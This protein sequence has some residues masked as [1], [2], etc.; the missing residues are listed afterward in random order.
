[1]GIFFVDTMSRLGKN[2][3]SIPLIALTY[4]KAKDVEAHKRQSVMNRVV[5]FEMS[6]VV[7]KILAIVL[8]YILTSM[9]ADEALAFKISFVLAGSMSLLYMLL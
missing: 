1:M 3:V 5:F 6:L 8:V 4:Q 2:I 7:G 9:I